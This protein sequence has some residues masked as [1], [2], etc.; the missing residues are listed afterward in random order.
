LNLNLKKNTKDSSKKMLDNFI[1][2]YPKYDVVKLLIFYGWH[3][4][5]TSLV[6]KSEMRD[7]CTDC[8]LD[9][10]HKFS[11]NLIFNL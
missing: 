7:N 1:N 4:N 9:F 11:N 6:I 10:I 8:A 5:N 2:N 3:G